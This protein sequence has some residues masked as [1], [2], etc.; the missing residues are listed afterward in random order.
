M[1]SQQP[2]YRTYFF[3]LFQTW[4]GI[5]FPIAIFAQQLTSEIQYFSKESGL[6][7]HRIL[8]VLEHSNGYVWVGTFNGL[9]RFDG[10]EFVP[11]NLPKRKQT[12][13]NTLDLYI[14]RLLELENGDIAV[15]YGDGSGTYNKIAILYDPES[16]Q[17]KEVV[18]EDFNYY[19][20][21]LEIKDETSVHFD[22]SKHETNGSTTL[23]YDHHGNSISILSI[24]GQS[25]VQLSLTSGDTLDL[26]KTYSSLINPRVFGKDFSKIIYLSSLNGMVKIDIHH[27]PFKS[28]LDSDLEEWG[29][30]LSGRAVADIGNGEILFSTE[31][32]ELVLLNAAKDELKTITF[33]DAKKNKDSFPSGSANIRSIYPQNDSIVWL[34]CYYSYGLVRLNTQTGYAKPFLLEEKHSENKF[35][36]SICTRDNEILIVCHNKNN[37]IQLIGFDLSTFKK[38]NYDFVPKLL[39]SLGARSTCLLESRNGT[40]WIGTTLGLFRIDLQQEK[41]LNAYVGKDNPVNVASDAFSKKAILP[42]NSVFSLFENKDGELLI[43]L[44]NGGLVVLDLER[45]SFESYTSSNGLPENTVC[46]ILPDPNGYWLGTFNGLSFFSKKEGHFRNFYKNNGL[47]HNEFNRFSSAKDSNG[48][49][50]FGGMNGFVSFDPKEVLQPSDSVNILL[51]KAIYFDQAGNRSV[52]QIENFGSIPKITIPASNRSASFYMCMTDLVDSKNHLYTYKLEPT[53][54]WFSST[55]SHWQPNGQNRKIQFDYLPS[56]SYRLLVKGTSA[57]GIATDNLVI[58]LVVKEFFYKTWWFIS[59]C[60]LTLLGVGYAFYRN[61]LAHVIKMERLRVRLSSDLH[62]DVGSLLSGVA[63]QMEL[64]EYTVDDRHKSLVQK[65]ASS[66]RRAMSQM[67]DVVWAIDS[68]NGTCQNL[69]DRMKE[70]AEEQLDPLN[71]QHSFRISALPLK[72]QLPAEVRHSMLHIF[73]EFISNTIKHSG[74]SK[75]DVELFERDGHLVM[76]L[77]DDGKGRDQAK[78]ST[79]QGLENMQMRADKINANLTFLTKDG[80]GIR[81]SVPGF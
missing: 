33:R 45:E 24:D 4:L 3:V 77:H 22:V 52:T 10:Y 17:T 11:I 69:V 37:Q 78:M 25:Y 71:I 44:D 14:S 1:E 41:V 35:I 65:I 42:S 74:A 54:S 18:I 48:I 7:D 47:P 49:N 60:F 6:T 12:T 57:Q 32:K 15:I 81:L 5:I 21:V 68:R 61:R 51:S 13:N 50:Y 46:S 56:G 16:Q 76:L 67:R 53:D 58:N 19:S 2:K 9:N 63:Y 70:F 8:A 72:K 29:Y 26:T 40:I 43:G 23:K 36:S 30:G 38:R 31:Q 39:S 64:L 28:Y 80:F 59:L 75:V 62:D 27:S 79:G 73:K 34:T 20:G 55:E 66:S